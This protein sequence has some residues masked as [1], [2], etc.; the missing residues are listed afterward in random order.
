MSTLKNTV[1][2][3][4][5]KMMLE[6]AWNKGLIK[7]FDKELYERLN[8]VYVACLPVSIQLKYYKPE[9]GDFGDCYARSMYLTTGFDNATLV[10]GVRK[11]MEI[12]YGIGNG[13]H[14]WVENDGWV[15]DPTSLLMYRKDIYY[16]AYG[17]SDVNSY[18][19]EV[20]SKSELYQGI[21]NAKIDDFKPGGEKRTDLIMIIPFT[22]RIAQ[23][24]NDKDFIEE[25][26]EFLKEIEYDY[27]SIINELQDDMKKLSRR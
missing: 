3:I 21:I 17:V 13:G 15:Y 6:K 26:N 14:G 16:K 4:K 23:L 2:N 8:K 1:Y 7:P 25:L 19:K 20:Y 24:R 27:E 22:E 11:D 10:R 18:S 9:R 12:A 5:R